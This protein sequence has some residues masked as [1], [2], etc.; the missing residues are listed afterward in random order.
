V[1]PTKATYLDF[2]LS[3]CKIVDPTKQLI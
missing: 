1:E 3:N 2:I